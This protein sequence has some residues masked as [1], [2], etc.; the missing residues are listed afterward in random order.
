MLY[1]DDLS[2]YHHYLTILRRRFWV[3][4][5]VVFVVISFVATWN[6]NT[7][8]SYQAT[9]QI[10]IE[11]PNPRILVFEE[12]VS[13][14]RKIRFEYYYETQSKLLQSETMLKQVVDELDL[15][16]RVGFGILYDDTWR[17][18]FIV[19]VVK[20]IFSFFKMDLS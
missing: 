11:P 5:T 4:L 12:I 1:K 20:P 10:L 2:I 13:A 3:I 17:K 15:S 6:F 7:R 16:R 14:G 18:K 19:P 8:P 9:T